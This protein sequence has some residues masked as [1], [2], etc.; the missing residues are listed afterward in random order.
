LLS[1]ENDQAAIKQLSLITVP[2]N[3]FNTHIYLNEICPI[4]ADP[5]HTKK[6]NDTDWRYGI[7][8]FSFQSINPNIFVQ[9]YLAM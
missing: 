4:K 9:R 8:L 2:A 3:I 1:K 6:L 7:N 5:A